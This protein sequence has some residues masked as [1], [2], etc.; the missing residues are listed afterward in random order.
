M[1]PR[2]QFAGITLQAVEAIAELFE[3]D[4]VRQ[5]YDLPDDTQGVWEVHYRAETGNI[6]ILMW[7]AI[8]R[9]DVAVGPHMWV[10][11]GITQFETIDGLEFIARFGD[12]GVLTVARNGQVI[13]TSP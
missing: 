8:D 7:P 2:Q 5:P 9:V 12:N 11:K 3:S 13:L 10:V 4:A 1:K 6:R